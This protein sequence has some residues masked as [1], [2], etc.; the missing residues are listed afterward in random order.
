VTTLLPREH[1]A[2]AQLLFPILSGLLMGRP[3]AA[4]A[5]VAL[6]AVLCFLAYEPLAVLRGI[7]GTRAR[8]EWGDRA[9]RRLAGLLP[10]AL[11]LA[12]LAWVL[13]WRGS[14]WIYLV[15]PTVLSILLLLLVFLGIAKSLAGEVAIA[16]GFASL[17]VAVGGSAALSGPLLWGPAVL[18]FAAFTAATFAVH[19]L[20]ERQAGRRS[21]LAAVADG[22][23]MASLLGVIV[24]ASKPGD[25]RF[26]GLAAIPPILAVFVVHFGRMTARH[27]K[28]IGWTLVAADVLALVIL[29]GKLLNI[30]VDP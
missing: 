27:L 11:V 13:M 24:L 26:L 15:V 10:A 6:A 25:L 2:Y 29:T 4:S 12:G 19:A 28:R 21:L 30:R 3:G 1:G 9:R 17:H 8:R 22:V 16:A 5:A 7:R 18:W 20:K 23:V 14:S